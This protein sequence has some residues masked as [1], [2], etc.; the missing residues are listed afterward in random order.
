MLRYLQLVPG[1]LAVAVSICALTA[2]SASNGGFG[3]GQQ[4][5]NTGTQTQLA[6]PTPGQT[7]VST[8]I[9][10]VIFV[11]NGNNN[12]LGTTYT[13]WQLTLVDNFG[14]VINGGRLALVPDPSGPHPYP[15]DF[16]Y[17][18]SIPQL[19]P[20]RSYTVTLGLPG[21]SCTSIGLGTFST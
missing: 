21:G 6:S 3:G 16:Y 14:T 18:S 7:G 1:W 9:G 20:G 10:Q 12:Q 17:A 8:T 5:C 19:S 15:S 11:A 2:C 4:I 13:Q